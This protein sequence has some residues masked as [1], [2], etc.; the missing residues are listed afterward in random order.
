[1]ATTTPPAEPISEV[2][3]LIAN[4]RNALWQFRALDQKSVDR[5]V[6]AAAK[7]ARDAHAALAHA[8]VKETQ[9]GNFEDKT[10]K[11]IFAAEQISAYMRDLKTVGIISQNQFTGITEIAEPVGIV[12]ALTPVTNPTSTTIF[13]ALMCLKT[14]NP[15][16]FAFHPS[17][18]Q[19][20]VMA[21]KIV[22]E[23]AVAAGAPEGCIQWITKPAMQTTSELMNHPDTAV[24]L[25][26]GGNAMV[27]AAYSC[28]KPALGVGAG[29]VPAYIHRSADVARAVYDVTASKSF[30]NGMICASEQAVILDEEIREQ[31][32]T[33]FKQLGCYV[34]NEEEKAKLE[35]LLFGAT[36]GT[37]ECATAKLNA[38]VVGQDAYTIAHDAGFKVPR[39]TQALLAEVSEV[40]YREPLTREKLSPVLAV[41][42][43]HST[44][45]GIHLAEQMVEQ[46]GLGH[47]GA[48]H[49]HD[50]DVIEEFGSRVQAVRIVANAP[51]SQGAIGGIFNAFVPSLTL[52]CGS[53]GH[54][55][56]SNNISAVNLINIKR[57]GRRNTVIAP[58]QVP[59]QIFQGVGTIRELAMITKLERVT[60]L[61]DKSDLHSGALAT[62]LQL[63]Y[64]RHNQVSVQVI[65]DIPRTLTADFL[66]E[67][68][69]EVSGFAP[70]TV[71]TFGSTATVNAG[72]IIR[73][74]LAH[75]ELD[76]DHVCSGTATL[77]ERVTSPRLVCVPTTSGGQAAL[78]SSASLPDP[79]SGL[80]L[81]IESPSFLADMVIMDPDFATWDAKVLAARGF[82]T[83]SQATETF[84]SINATDFTDAL[85]LRGLE[86]SYFSLPVAV[87]GFG[88]SAQAEAARERVI[89]A[90][91]LISTAVGNASLGLADS[92]A[93]A[94]SQFSGAPRQDL[95]PAILPNVVRFNGSLPT[96]LVTWPNYETFTVP[97]RCVEI[98]R[99]LGITVG[100]A[101]AVEAYAVALED[102][103][104]QIGAVPLLRNQGLAESTFD[105]RIGDIVE[106]AFDYQSHSGNPQT[107]RLEDIH[108]LLIA[109]FR[110]QKYQR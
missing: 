36:A 84:L 104:D 71:L 102:L 25:A 63:L 44:D 68:A 85:A 79:K 59:P 15:V 17:A 35:K 72:K 61:S 6:E 51:S 62:V 42:T 28:G 92:L 11:N 96:K 1:M 83:I 49:A 53:Y 56:V 91:T 109:C 19:C 65:D 99:H 27:R 54:N 32:L 55:S 50:R 31:A 107:A 22:Q 41:L 3:E 103:R 13:K 21:A 4:A 64:S 39:H 66:R 12:T 40:S 46:D 105:H 57:I 8:A 89:S 90:G 94:F 48:I 58:F 16:I 20:C 38:K 70:D 14:R 98:C 95:L 60:I 76:L 86:L 74:S 77:P 75:P 67:K 100:K 81:L 106:R 33:T 26:T 2:D 97:D 110:G 37:E 87:K 101:G 29:N 23:A 18:Q 80:E 69:T 7:A 34:V 45:E 43:A 10:V 52:G 47:T 9:R 73:L 24:I 93:Q 88:S 108:D 5:V 78:S 82:E 30:D